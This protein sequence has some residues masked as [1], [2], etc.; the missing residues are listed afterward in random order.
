M[1]VVPEEY[2][3]SIRTQLNLLV[4]GGLPHLLFWVERYPASLVAQPDAI[5]S[6]GDSEI[7]FRDDGTA[8]GVLPLWT[9]DES[10]SDLSA[11]IEIAV[12][13]LAT[14]TAVRVL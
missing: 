5:W 13:G 14:I 9:T 10:P 6:H 7:N 8:W 1:G 2:R 3:A 11:E 4:S 12:D